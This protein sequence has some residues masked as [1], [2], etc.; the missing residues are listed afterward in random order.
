MILE[1]RIDTDC[2]TVNE[3]LQIIKIARK[4]DKEFK[5]EIKQFLKE[6]T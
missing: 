1:L 5:K 4:H 2:L 6:Y 3:L